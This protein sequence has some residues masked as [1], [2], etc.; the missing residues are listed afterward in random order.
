MKKKDLNLDDEIVNGS[1]LFN[2]GVVNNEIVK[3]FMSKG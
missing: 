2:K 1:I 3:N